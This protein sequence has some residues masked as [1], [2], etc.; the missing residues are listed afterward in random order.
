MSK[1][2]WIAVHVWFLVDFTV[3]SNPYDKPVCNI[4]PYGAPD[5][6]DCAY[7]LERFT[8]SQD[9]QLRIFD[10][11]QLRAD[12]DGA[13]PGIVNP[14]RERVVQIPRFWSKSRE[15]V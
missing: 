1:L 15:G 14:F 8:N 13:W 4:Y 3:H 9:T 11:E 6:N 7:L 12:Q 2:V 5:F 10:E